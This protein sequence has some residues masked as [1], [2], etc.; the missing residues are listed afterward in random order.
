RYTAHPGVDAAR[1]SKLEPEHPRNASRNAR[2]TGNT[3]AAART[4]RA[5]GLDRARRTAADEAGPVDATC[6][7]G[8]PLS[9]AQITTQ[10]EPRA[11]ID[12]HGNRRV[13]AGRLLR[14][15]SGHRGAGA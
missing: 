14:S 12:D 9:G 2:R 4:A 13:S 6:A 3:V 7:A 11:G 10:F 8:T 5:R 15:V 1:R